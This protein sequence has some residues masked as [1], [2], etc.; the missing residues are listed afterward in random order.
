MTNIQKCTEADIYI[1]QIPECN[2]YYIRCLLL[3]S[4]AAFLDIKV[5]DATQCMSGEIS[6]KKKFI[7]KFITRNECLDCSDMWI[8]I[9]F[10]IKKGSKYFINRNVELLI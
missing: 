5:F 10:D 8:I 4:F 2:S 3:Y 1:R 7:A 6:F 9:M